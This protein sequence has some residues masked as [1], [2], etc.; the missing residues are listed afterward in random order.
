[1]TVADAQAG[2][3]CSP[4]DNFSYQKGNA[5]MREENIVYAPLAIY[6]RAEKRRRFFS[7]SHLRP[8][9]AQWSIQL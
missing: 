9:P 6:E 5:F 4:Q 2:V 8:A 1:V 7:V 3:T